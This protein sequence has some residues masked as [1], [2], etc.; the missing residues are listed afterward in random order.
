MKHLHRQR[1]RSGRQSEYCRIA[2]CTHGHGSA[3]SGVRV[4]EIVAQSLNRVRSELTL[5]RARDIPCPPTL[6]SS[7]TTTLHI[8]TAIRL[9]VVSLLV[10]RSGSSLKT[11]VSLDW[12]YQHLALRNRSRHTVEVEGE[13]VSNASIHNGAGRKVA[14]L[15]HIGLTCSE[16]PHMVPLRA[17]NE[18]HGRSVVVSTEFSSCSSDLSELVPNIEQ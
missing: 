1:A 13:W 9:L 3:G 10:S 15:I 7:C 5:N 11:S 8:S 16:E 2:G 12:R 4:A 6:L 18:G 17:H 14:G